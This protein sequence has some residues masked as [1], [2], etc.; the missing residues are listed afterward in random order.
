MSIREKTIRRETDVA[1]IGGGLVGGAVAYGLAR[2][3]LDVTVFDEGDQAFRASRGNFGLVWVQTKGGNEPA[4]A[5]WSWKSSELWKGFAAELSEQTAIDLQLAQDGGLIFCES[6]EEM[7]QQSDLL[8]GIRSQ[9]GG[10]YPY[11][12]LGNNQLRKLMPEAGPDVPG[13]SWCPLDGHVNPLKLMM[14]L[15]KA[16]AANGGRLVNGAKASNIRSHEGGYEITSGS[17]TWQAGKLVLAAGLGNKALAAQVGLNAP[18]EP[19]RGQVLITERLKPFMEYPTVHVRQTAEGTIQ[20][21]DS[22][23][24]VGL[25]AGTSLD[26]YGRIARRAVRFFPK[27]EHVRLIRA[28]GALRVMSP[29]GLPIYQESE[30]HKGAYVVTCH[31]GVTLA[32]MHAGPVAGWIAGQ[33][34]PEDL[35]VFS[36]DRFNV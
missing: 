4:Y 18:V 7:Q 35:T 16:F 30:S 15:H 22:K 23:E 10:D 21:G 20:I 25:N 29:D 8:A 34:V 17:E 14:A 12:M 32:A 27:L 5:R 19:N 11:E 13:A 26:V 28:W 36:G 2:Q 33:S 6:E 31:S 9:L 3:G 1:V 24:D